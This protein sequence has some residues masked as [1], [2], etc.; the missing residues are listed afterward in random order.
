LYG[1][2]NFRVDLLSAFSGIEE[3]RLVNF[4]PATSSV[5][6]PGNLTAQVS[7]VGDNQNFTFG[8]NSALTVSVNGNF[9]TFI[10]GSGST[11]TITASASSNGNTYRLGSGT[12]I[13]DGGGGSDTF[14]V[15]TA[16]A[17]TAA[18]S[19]DGRGSFDTLQFTSLPTGTTLDIRG[20]DQQNIEQLNVSM[21]NG[22]LLIDQ[23][24]LA[25]VQTINGS[26]TSVLVT[27]EATLNLTNRSVSSVRIQSSNPDGTV[28]TTNNS[29]TAFQIIGGPG[30]DTLN[31]QGFAL[32]ADQRSFVF[33]TTSIDVIRDS[34]GLYGNNSG[35]TLSGTNA[36]ETILGGSGSDVLIGALGSDTLTGGLGGDEFVFQSP[37]E[38]ADTILDFG[39]GDDLIVVDAAAFGGGLV[40]G[41][42]LAAA[43]LVAN[44]APVA[45][46][47]QGQFLYD[48][49]SGQ[50]LW[51]ADGTGA[52]D[53]ILLATLTGAPSVTAADFEL[54]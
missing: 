8:N 48:T 2:G 31:L 1:A 9:N 10:M 34:S 43:Q 45:T 7:S 22:T 33:V 29:S 28:F 50:L 4:I 15:L 38:G 30:E 35:N 47:A 25:A 19:L 32:T 26:T 49:D 51:D 53:P 21:T 41:A 23:Q 27:A 46:A 14:Q 18:D 44:S 20:L 36:G 37:S 54:V 17:F 11:T 13:I 6:L 24:S 12:E 39:A 3:I 40:A 5:T 42:P 16:T 52:A